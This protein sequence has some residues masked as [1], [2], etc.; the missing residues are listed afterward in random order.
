MEEAPAG[1][2]HYSMSWLRGDD[3]AAVAEAD[4]KQTSSVSAISR[5]NLGRWSIGASYGAA[6]PRPCQRWLAGCE[7]N[8]VV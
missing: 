2:H 7:V 3:G 1:I 5:P 8:D 6:R 4:K